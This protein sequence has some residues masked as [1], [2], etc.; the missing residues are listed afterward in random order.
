MMPTWQSR[1]LLEK[2]RSPAIDSNVENYLFNWQKN[3]LES[4]TLSVPAID[5]L[6]D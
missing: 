6:K 1:D 4:I 2:P 5:N 3:P